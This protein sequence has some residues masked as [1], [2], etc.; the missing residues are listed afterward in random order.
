MRQT[1]YY[2]GS[3]MTM[4]DD[5]PTAEAVLV[6]DGVI[7]AVGEYEELRSKMNFDAEQFDLCGHTMLPGFIDGHSHMLY[8]AMFPRFDGPPV[9]NIDSI[10]KLVASAQIYLRQH[11]VK[12]GDWLVGMGYDNYFFANHRHPTVE[13]MDRISTEVPV[14]MMHYSGHIGV[15]NSKI[16]EICGFTKDTPNPEGALFTRTH[17]P[18]NRL[19]L[20]K[21]WRSLVMSLKKCHCQ[22]LMTLIVWYCVVRRCIFVTGLPP[23]RM[24]P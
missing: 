14:L 5:Q 12:K 2:H 8:S 4:N 11:P 17:L 7:K 21:N 19:V 23:Y 13:D 15:C 24:G 9:G 6:E 3:I 10:E 1:L 22:P 18:E 16:L 20:W